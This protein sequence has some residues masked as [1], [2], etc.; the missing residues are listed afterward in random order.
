M[1]GVYQW[2]TALVLAFLVFVLVFVFLGRRGPGARRAA[3]K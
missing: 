2:H 3:G 1:T